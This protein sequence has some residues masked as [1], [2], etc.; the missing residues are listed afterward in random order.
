M[1]TQQLAT[2]LSFEVLSDGGGVPRE[3]TGIYCCD[4]LSIV[5]GQAQAGDVWI[6]V[7]GNL[8]A[9]A[10]AVLA[11]VPCIVLAHH[12]NMTQECIDKAIEENIWILRSNQAVYPIAQAIAQAIAPSADL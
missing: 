6:T 2:A 3:I 12:A 5:M 11:D 9:V 8:N 1:T 4:L 7:M 10:V